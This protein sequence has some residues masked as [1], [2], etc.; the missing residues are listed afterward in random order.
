MNSAWQVAPW[1]RRKPKDTSASAPR[2]LRDG[3]SPDDRLRL[4]STGLFSPWCRPCGSKLSVVGGQPAND[5][6]GA[7]TP[8]KADGD[9]REGF[10]VLTC[11]HAVGESCVLQHIYGWQP[12]VP[13]CPQSSQEFDHCEQGL[14]HPGC[15]H[16]AMSARLE[17]RPG[18]NL[19]NAIKAGMPYGPPG[20]LCPACSTSHGGPRSRFSEYWRILPGVVDAHLDP[21]P[22]AVISSSTSSSSSF[23]HAYLPAPQP[24]LSSA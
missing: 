14:V 10:V 21:M 7:P 24:R 2:W 11:G 5:R 17:C 19:Y 8:P 23:A 22:V 15:R 20:M 9:Y 6:P 3:L 12:V 1:D 18:L 16:L 13:V 4:Q